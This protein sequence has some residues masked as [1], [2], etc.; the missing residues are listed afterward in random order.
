M[1]VLCN[2]PVYLVLLLYITVKWVCSACTL[3]QTPEQEDWVK[4]SE[5]DGTEDMMMLL[6]EKQVEVEKNKKNQI[7]ERL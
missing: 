6:R 2:N 7:E 3:T 5:E 4:Q 1:L